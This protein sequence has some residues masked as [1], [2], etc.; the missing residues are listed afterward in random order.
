MS[1]KAKK[2][3]K[4]QEGCSRT[5]N[6]SPLVSCTF[7]RPPTCG[8][9]DRASVMDADSLSDPMLWQFGRENSVH[10]SCKAIGLC[11]K[12]IASSQ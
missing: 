5:H 10:F 11:K 12:F 1:Q 7:T 6:Y 4:S 9:E 3:A 8:F 2:D